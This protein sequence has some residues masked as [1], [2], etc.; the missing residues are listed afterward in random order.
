MAADATA[1]DDILDKGWA[2]RI[3]DL[4]DNSKQLVML[5]ERDRESLVGKAFQVPIESQRNEGGGARSE[6]GTL[7]PAGEV[8]YSVAEYDPK[9]IWWQL[10]I[11][12]FLIELSEKDPNRFV[13]ALQAETD[14]VIKAMAEDRDRMFWG[15]G[16]GLLATLGTTSAST[17]VTCTN[18]KFIRVNMR[19]DILVKSTGAVS[20]GATDRKVTAV[21]KDTSFVIDGAAVTT[22]STFG[23]YRAG[24]KVLTT[25]YE[26]NGLQNIV[27]STGAV[28]T[29]NPSTAG[30]DFWA[31]GEYGSIGTMSQEEPQQMWED[32]AQRGFTVSQNRIVISSF[33]VRREYGRIL[34]ASVRYNAPTTTKAQHPKLAGTNY[35]ALSFNGTDWLAERKCPTGEAY[36]VDLDHLKDY[37]T[38][39]PGWKKRQGRVLIDDG[40]TGY[41][42]K[43]RVFENLGTDARWAHAKMT[44]I[45]EAP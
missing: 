28:G 12:E 41:V 36:A 16:T 32:A 20:T 17:T 33:G 26:T 11:T 9:H 21:T 37:Q 14:G 1:Y 2:P 22:D 5:L 44:G 39:A 4:F 3:Q 25:H 6:K 45:T 18:T 31:A 7:A 19:V 23:V 10:G 29:L 42:G 40:G 43:Y 8:G 13:Q 35:D 27:D 24:N 30:L 34:T 15:D 38:A